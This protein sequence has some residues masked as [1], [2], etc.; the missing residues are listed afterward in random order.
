MQSTAVFML[1][2]LLAALACT[3]P[4]T[5]LESRFATERSCPEENVRVMP[6]GGVAYDV[7][8]C[9]KSARY[10]CPSFSARHSNAR[11]CQE[12]GL[13][14]RPEPEPPPVQ[15]RRPNEPEQSPR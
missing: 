10:I 8:G 9:D 13:P 1:L 7:Q 15:P 3:G 12:R 6:Q 4:Q 14:L 2:M 11:Q 5:S